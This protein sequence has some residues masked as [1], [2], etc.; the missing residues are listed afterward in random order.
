MMGSCILEVVSASAQGVGS[1]QSRS[2][3]T[4]WFEASYPVAHLIMLRII[5]D[6]TTSGYTE[7]YP[8]MGQVRGRLP[9]A[10]LLPTRTAITNA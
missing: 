8:A 7:R 10:P 4:G 6:L 1:W 3:L 2:G 5:D 9:L